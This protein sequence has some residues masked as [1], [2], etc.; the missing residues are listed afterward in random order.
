MPWIKRKLRG[1]SVFVRVDAKG[2]PNTNERGLVEIIYKLK[3]DSKIYNA[4]WNNLVP[5]GDDADEAPFETEDAPKPGEAP[6]KAEAKAKAKTIAKG[7]ALTK[8]AIII[9]TDGACSRN[10]GP[11]GIGAVIVN[12]DDRKEISEFLGTG[13]NNI[14]EL[15]AIGRALEL[16]PEADRQ[17]MVVVHT[18]SS[19]SIGVLDK[20][21]KAKANTE[22]IM[23]I[24]AQIKEFGALQFVKVKGH[25]GIP[26][27]ERCDELATTAVSRGH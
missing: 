13:T 11:A 20:G 23:G 14:A 21:W 24:R 22:L 2:Q 7:P 17:R 4:S 1:N 16:V 5:T 18:D 3:T 12:G 15:T 19:Y 10:P 26:E 8:D 25:A 6:P 27:N 9:Y